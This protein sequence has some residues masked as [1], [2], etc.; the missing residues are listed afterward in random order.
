MP[1]ERNRER[2]RE[3]KRLDLDTGVRESI[4]M[5]VQKSI[6]S[7]KGQKAGMWLPS[8]RDGVGGR[9]RKEHKRIFGG[10][11]ND[12]SLSLSLSQWYCGF[13]SG[14]HL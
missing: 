9:A 14:L 8:I 6:S 12:L 1:S 4:Y 11:E 2:E 3:G 10:D 5:K 13:N 7:L